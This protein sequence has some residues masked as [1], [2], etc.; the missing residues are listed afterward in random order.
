MCWRGRLGAISKRAGRK[1]ALAAHKTFISKLTLA[2]GPGGSAS[3]RT[4]SWYWYISLA[5]EDL[6][7]AQ[8]LHIFIIADRDQGSFVESRRHLLTRAVLHLG[9][10]PH[11]EYILGSFG[12]VLLAVRVPGYAANLSM[13]AG[14]SQQWGTSCCN[15]RATCLRSL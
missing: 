2:Y 5:A 1:D 14:Q 10:P 11:L 9:T 7:P 13:A 3:A 12:P 4:S 15:G 8:H 6:M